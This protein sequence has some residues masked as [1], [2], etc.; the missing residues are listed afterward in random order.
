V[1]A[2]CHVNF[3]LFHWGPLLLFLVTA[4]FPHPD[5]LRRSIPQASLA[6][7]YIFSP[8]RCPLPWWGP[9]PLRFLQPWLS[10]A[11]FWSESGD[12]L[13]VP[14]WPWPH[15]PPRLGESPRTFFT[16]PSNCAGANG[17]VSITTPAAAYVRSLS[18]Y[19]R[20]SPPFR[21]YPKKSGM[22]AKNSVNLRSY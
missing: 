13:F 20:H 8:F 15:P 11:F 5:H 3:C 19:P 12:H 6:T 7:D 14:P 21:S 10:I 22:G 2:P 16:T 9:L 17:S 4:I 18:P 1:F